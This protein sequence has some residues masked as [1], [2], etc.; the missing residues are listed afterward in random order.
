[1]EEAKIEREGKMLLIKLNGLSRSL[2]A[3]LSKATKE[4]E[5][6]MIDA[7]TILRNVH[8]LEMELNSLHHTIDNCKSF[9]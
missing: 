2:F 7:N 3:D 4:V 8:G 1:M 5:E 9:T 6:A